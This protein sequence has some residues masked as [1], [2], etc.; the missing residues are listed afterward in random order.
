M[1]VC[2][3]KIEKLRGNFPDAIFG[4]NVQFFEIL[5]Y[6]YLRLKVFGLLK[7]LSCQA[8]DSICQRSALQLLEF[9]FSRINI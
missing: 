8:G 1:L 5:N 4:V 9:A 6:A 7:V 3:R 2:N